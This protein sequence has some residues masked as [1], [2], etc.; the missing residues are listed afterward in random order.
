MLEA[1]QRTIEATHLSYGLILNRR[2]EPDRRHGPPR[3][4][5]PHANG[6]GAVEELFHGFLDTEP[7]VHWD[8]DAARAEPQGVASQAVASQA[9]ASQVLASPAEPQAAE[10]RRLEPPRPTSGSPA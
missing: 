2:Q 5:V 4:A 8:T 9:V 10:P 3:D 7:Q 1:A 6:K